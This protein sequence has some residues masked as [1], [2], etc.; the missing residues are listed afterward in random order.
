MAAAAENLSWVAAGWSPPAPGR[1]GP[2]GI[3][4][5]RPG[6]A[7]GDSPAAA[8]AGRAPNPPRAGGRAGPAPHHLV[9]TLRRAHA[10]RRPRSRRGPLPA[11][12]GHGRERGGRRPV[13]PGGRDPGRAAGGRRTADRAL[14]PPLPR[15]GRRRAAALRSHG[16]SRGP[17]PAARRHHR[18]PPRSPRPDR[19][20]GAR[21]HPPSST[22]SATGCRA[23]RCPRPSA[24]SSGG[25]GWQSL[26]CWNGS[27]TFYDEVAA[28]RRA[29]PRLRIVNQL[30]NHHGG[31]IEHYSPSLIRAVDA[32]IAVNTPIARALVDDHGVPDDR[33][34]TIHHAVGA[35]DPR[36][37]DRRARAPPRARRR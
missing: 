30:F 2:S 25:G 32:Q 31:W 26:V 17:L 10:P 21:A 9:R 29:F 37:E 34:V 3:V 33:V 4:A 28:L 18:S 6:D 8:P 35:P 27:V 5:A 23:R 1:F 16:G 14:S 11:P 36:D 19:R 24:T 12:P 7:G 20:P 15:G 22:P 13:V